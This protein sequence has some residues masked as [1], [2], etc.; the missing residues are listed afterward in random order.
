MEVDFRRTTEGDVEVRMSHPVEVILEGGI[1]IAVGIGIVIGYGRVKLRVESLPPV[2]HTILI[3][4]EV[5]RS[6]LRPGGKFRTGL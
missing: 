3:C 5:G 1:T 4:V 6:F 2:R